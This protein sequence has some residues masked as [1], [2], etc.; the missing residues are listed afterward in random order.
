MTESV[1]AELA[2][3]KTKSTPELRAQWEELFGR[4]A[5]PYGRKMLEA[6]IG[7]RLQELWLGGLS[8]RARRRLDALVDLLEPKAARR[9]A[10]GRPIA[11]TQLRRHWKNV[12]HVV[13]VRERK[14]AS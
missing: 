11:G 12:E 5:P 6:R 10:P 1:L 3:L 2:A 8:E 7:Y 4:P 14:P 13:T 9:R